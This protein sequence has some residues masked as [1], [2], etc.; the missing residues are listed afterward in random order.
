MKAKFYIGIITAVL[1]PGFLAQAQIADSRDYRNDNAGTIVNNYYDYD[2]YYSSRI[3]RFHR[4][5]STFDYYSPV[6]TDSYWYNYEPYSWGLSIYGGGGFGFGLSYNFPVYYD[7]GWNNPYFGSSFN[8]GYDPFYY[9]WFSPFVIN[10][11][12]GNRWN[13]NYYSWHG[14]NRWDYDY[15]HNYNTYNNYYYNRYQSNNR[16]SNSDYSRRNESVNNNTRANN[17][18]RREGSNFTRTDINGDGR[19]R[20]NSGVYNGA[21]NGETRRA[22]N[23]STNRNTINNGN[24]G[25]NN[26]ITNY[27][28]RGANQS[29][30]NPSNTQINRRS[31]QLPDR[32]RSNITSRPVQSNSSENVNTNA[33]RSVIRSESASTSV[34]RTNASSG[35][36]SGSGRSVSAP[37]RSSSSTVRSSSSSSRNSS[38]SKSG[39]TTSGGS[40]SSKEKGRRK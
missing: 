24:R 2:Y 17:V 9:N 16:P 38:S 1:L 33:N 18:S 28:N 19:N 3:N 34:R 5:F 10:I 6:F 14:R 7:W 26:V 39:S 11:G 29:V 36:N 23:P 25:T 27:P 35:N 4:S 20:T 30:T 15:R 40:S 8:W 31:E 21:N 37:S 12:I 22:V 13:H 32:S